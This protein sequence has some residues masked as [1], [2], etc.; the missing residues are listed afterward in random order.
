MTSLKFI[1]GLLLFIFIIHF[2]A[3]AN[4][5]YWTY[6]WLDIPMHFFGGFWVAMVYLYLI[7]PKLSITNN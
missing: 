4:H 3:L 5:W 6:S 2:L 1:I 7:N